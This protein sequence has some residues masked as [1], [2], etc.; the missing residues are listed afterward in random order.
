MYEIK[1]YAYRLSREVTG[2]GRKANLVERGL[3]DPDLFRQAEGYV[4]AAINV[5][6]GL[7]G[8]SEATVAKEL[9]R[10][11][12][13][14]SG[15]KQDLIYEAMMGKPYQ[16]HMSSADVAAGLELADMFPKRRIFQSE[17]DVVR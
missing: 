13:K 9:G 6:Q 14:V 17:A 2:W 15:W 10:G 16:A 5:R 1:E 8:A 4:K 11:G 3:L 7:P 12:F